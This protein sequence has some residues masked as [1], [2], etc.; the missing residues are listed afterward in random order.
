MW[1]PCGYLGH[2][3]CSAILSGNQ[4]IS[5]SSVLVRID[6]SSYIWLTFIFHVQ[7]LL[8]YNYFFQLI[9]FL[10]R[11]SNNWCATRSPGDKSLSPTF[12]CSECFQKHC[13]VPYRIYNCEYEHSLLKF[14]KNA[15]LKVLKRKK[16]K[17]KKSCHCDCKPGCP[18]CEQYSSSTLN[19]LA[20]PIK[21][22]GYSIC[23]ILQKMTKFKSCFFRKNWSKFN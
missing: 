18:V 23:S 20:I 16:H 10:K 17:Q 22:L 15:F 13:P 3:I 12:L 9:F 4:N 11:G 7:S 19:W 5:K 6:Q 1:W 2:D 8:L 21:W 14:I